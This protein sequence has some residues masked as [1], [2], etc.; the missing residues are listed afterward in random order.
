MPYQ[1]SNYRFFVQYSGIAIQM[2]V[3]MGILAWIGSVIDDYC[4]TH[5]PIFTLIGLLLGIISSIY[6]LIKNLSK[7]EKIKH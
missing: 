5:S 2:I 1:D 4:K 3:S 6:L 7:N